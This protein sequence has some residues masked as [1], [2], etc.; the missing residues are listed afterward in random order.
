MTLVSRLQKNKEHPLQ[1]SALMTL[2]YA[3]N[4]FLFDNTT[5][6][7]RPHSVDIVKFFKLCIEEVS[8]KVKH[9]IVVWLSNSSPRRILMRAYVYTKNMT[10]NV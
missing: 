2:N 4:F 5:K 7:K 9:K 10:V 6:G 1:N 3:W 8:Q